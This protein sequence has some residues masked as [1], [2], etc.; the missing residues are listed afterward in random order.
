MYIDLYRYTHTCI[1]THI[2]VY[3]YAINVAETQPEAQAPAAG[4][5]REP[6]FCCCRYP[7]ICNSSNDNNNNNEYISNSNNDNLARR[8]RAASAEKR[9]A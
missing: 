3:V 2:C 8:L 7:Y 4:P 5:S 9:E 6:L 1:H